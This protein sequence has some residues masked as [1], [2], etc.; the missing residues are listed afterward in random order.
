MEAL[1]RFRKVFEA[2]HEVAR[3]WKK[4]TGKKVV[5]H[6]CT[7]TPREMIY[8]AGMLPVRVFGSH[9]PP[10]EMSAQHM[11]SV[12]CPY[13]HDVLAQALRGRYG[14]LSG[15][16]YARCCDHAEQIWYN[17]RNHAP[18]ELAYFIYMPANVAA[19]RSLPLLVEEYGDFKTALEKLAGRSVSDEDL[20]R[21]VGLFNENR[22]LL[23]EVWEMRKLDDPPLTGA[24]AM[25]IVLAE[26]VMDVEEHTNLLKD[27]LLELPKRKRNRDTGVRLMITGG[28]NDD[29]K[30]LRFV[31][32]KLG[33]TFVI[34]EHCAGSRYF[35]D[36]VEPDENRVKALARRYIDRWPCPIV[37]WKER[38]RNERI[39]QIAKDYRVEGVILYQ[40]KFCDPH[41]FANPPLEKMFRENGIPTL[42]LEFDVMIPVGQFRT[43]IEAFLEPITL[44]IL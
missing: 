23:R 36:E 30:F 27:L 31:E 19:P 14:Y 44:Q 16:V 4:R 38:R 10:Q 17:W 32:E 39:L 5:G 22:R 35:W 6:I 26:Q 11:S 18:V 33:A 12:I 13:C 41:E 3:E 37:D 25:E 15:L 1:E 20:D 28:E 24:E 34:E 42:R 29:T 7:Y 40:Q 9:E 43:R 2:R 21:A 8:A